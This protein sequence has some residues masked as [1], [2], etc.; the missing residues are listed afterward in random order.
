MFKDVI[1]DWPT[2][3]RFI[4]TSCDDKYF[5]QYFPR[6]YKT[7][8]Q[9]WQLPI[10]VHII[11]PSATSL[12]RLDKLDVT[13]THCTTDKSVLRFPY[14]YETYCQAQRFI[15]LGNNLLENQSDLINTLITDFKSSTEIIDDKNILIILQNIEKQLSDIIQNKETC[16]LFK[17]YITLKDK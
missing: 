4:L 6:F 14:S 16:L 11:D 13:Y 5:E 7:Y 17:N 8:K 15:L 10:H 2:L 1:G 12:Q 9:H 3:E